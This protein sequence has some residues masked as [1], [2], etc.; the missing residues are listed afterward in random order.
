MKNVLIS[1]SCNSEYENFDW[2]GQLVAYGCENL[3]FIYDTT[4]TKILCALKGH[5]GRVNCVRF[6]DDGKIMSVCASGD[7]IIW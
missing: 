4:K 6:F 2:F 3:V 5:A 1:G 7:F